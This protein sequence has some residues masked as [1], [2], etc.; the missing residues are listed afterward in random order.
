MRSAPFAGES[1][2]GLQQA[3][4]GLPIVGDDPGG[5]GV[6]QRNQPPRL[7]GRAKQHQR[8]KPADAVCRPVDS[9][10]PDDRQAIDRREGL[11][12]GEGMG[13]QRR[14]V[15]AQVAVPGFFVASMGDLKHSLQTL[16]GPA[17]QP[18]VRKASLMLLSL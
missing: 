10:Q 3:T 6:G 17:V 5:I 8:Q 7:S 15:A 4:A 11:A 2:G 12:P 18:A 14:P 16:A 13:K 9:R 1:Q